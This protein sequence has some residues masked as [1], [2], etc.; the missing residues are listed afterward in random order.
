MKAYEIKQFEKKHLE[1]A[2][3]LYC[4]RVKQER[5]LCP[6][7]PGRYEDP[8]TILQK[9][10]TLVNKHGGVVAFSGNKPVGYFSGMPLDPWRG[11]R[12]VWVPEWAHAETG[13]NRLNIFN[14][15]YEHIAQ[16]WIRD[17]CFT[18][19]VSVL[20]HYKEIID[21]LG[22]LGFG[23]VAVDAMRETG[24]VLGPF[25]D[26]EI[27]RAGIEDTDIVLSL[28]HD[29]QRY[30]STSPTFM[31]LEEPSSKEDCLESLADPT[32]ATWLASCNGEVV[33]R[34]RIGLSDAY[35]L[36][37]DKTANISAAFTKEH[38]RSKGI[39]AVLLKH[40]LE[41]AASKGGKRCAVDFEPENVLGRS[42]WL[43]HFQPVSISFI[44]N[45]DPRI[46]RL[47]EN[48]EDES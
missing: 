39:A 47:N 16:E 35:I 11:R 9:L 8:G 1:E 37:D 24:E 48:H 34:M 33:S 38:F 14:D 2:A 17:G 4:E 46:G 23:M 42:F 20:A 31:A 30:M 43:K 5:A 28:I 6:L 29:H 45:V 44:R 41:W 27:R 10:E 36:T 7:L 32:Q 21:A 22:W 26:V 18:H 15:M 19:L 40:S 12:S 13:G 3:E 25:A